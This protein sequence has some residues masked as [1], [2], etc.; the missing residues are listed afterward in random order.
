[1]AMHRDLRV[2]VTGGRFHPGTAV[3]RALG[4]AGVRVDAADSYKLVPVLHSHAVQELHV[5]PSP[6]REP[7]RFAQAVAQIVREREI[8]VVV[9][10]FE[11]GFYLARYSALIPVP[12]FAPP[13]ETVA[14]LH[15][16]FRFTELCAGLGLRTPVTHV[17]RTRAELRETIREFEHFVARPA[18][19]RG[20]QVYL[21]N[22]GPR[23]LE[24]TVDDCEPTSDNPWLVQEYVDGD[25]ACSFSIVRDGEIVVHCPY[26][27]TIPTPGG[28]SV[29][30]GSIEDF[31]SHEAASAIA[32]AVGYNGFLSFD[33]RRTKDGLVMIECN[34]RLSGGVF[35]TPEQWVCDAMMGEDHVFRMVE[36]GHRRQYDVY[37]LDPHTIRLPPRQLVHELL[38]TP[39]ALMKADDVLPAFFFLINRRH[40]SK[41][42]RRE[43]I[44]A[45]R[46][47]VEDITWDG[48]PMPEI[49]D[50]C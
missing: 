42:G 12:L 41:L 39:D 14:R 35:L 34:P 21:T 18:F 10:V 49:P 30:F 5:V 2:L 40:W 8:D 16:K 27:P 23:A 19:S 26:E 37:L 32:A 45:G 4:A 1:M 3:V 29:Q 46:A 17:V 25:D 22:H 28:W 11:E 50:A 44:S 20:G 24:S 6:S 15:N 47:F 48:S 33:Y 31:G 38:T 43:H 7:V 13:F 36:P 9:P